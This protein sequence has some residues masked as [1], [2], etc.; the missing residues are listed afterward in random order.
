[1]RSVLRKAS[2]PDL[3]LRKDQSESDALFL[4]IGEGALVTD[5]EGRIS[6]INQVALDILG[7]KARE[8]I[9]K[10]YPSMVIAEDNHGQVLSNLERPI[11]QVFL[12]GQTITAKIYYRRKDGSKVPVDL[13]VSPVLR[14]G[15]PIGAIEVFRDITKE[16]A[17]Q[18]A[19]DDFI[20]IASHQLRTPAT[21][22]K[23][24]V[25]MFLE[26]YAGRLSASQRKL[27]KRAYESNERQLM[28]IEDLLNIA[29]LDAGNM[30]LNVATTDLV[31]ILEDVISEQSAKAAGRRQEL[32]LNSSSDEVAVN[33]DADRM[34]MV[35]ENLIDN[36]IKYTPENKKIQV[37][38][39]RFINSAEVNIVDEGVGI[40]PVDIDKL[41]R[42]FSRVP[43]PLSIESG[44]SGLG[45]YWAERIIKLHNGRIKINS[46]P[47]KGST[48]SVRLPV[49][50]KI[51][52]DKISR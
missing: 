32:S 7:F 23:Q 51:I 18:Q 50:S 26:G 25:G 24:Y 45:L 36:A 31:L 33:I 1:M 27:L 41:F 30:K 10:W 22:V 40:A 37:N 21:A 2:R 9:G 6:R 5:S 4:S 47:G 19:K 39:R 3:I 20:S 52:T 29:R 11:T 42:K 34:R 16:L 14:N 8:L 35:F 48:F 13:T 43:N 12:T 15:K 38:I 17:L 44:G 46:K 49:A 28:I